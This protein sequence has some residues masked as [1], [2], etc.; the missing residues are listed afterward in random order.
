MTRD[1][2]MAWAEVA[3]I[4]RWAYALSSTA[5]SDIYVL[6]RS[7]G[8]WAVFYSERGNRNDERWYPAEAQALQDLKYR[9][10]RDGTARRRRP[11]VT[12]MG[13]PIDLDD[14]MVTVA[15]PWGD[16]KVPLD[17]W[18]RKGP[19]PRPFVTIVAARRRS[20]EAPVDLHEIAL[21]Y[22]N[23]FASRHLQRLGRLKAPWGRPPDEE[24]FD[25]EVVFQRH[26]AVGRVMM[27]PSHGEREL[28]TL[29]PPVEPSFD[30]AALVTDLETL[31]GLPVTVTPFPRG[32]GW[33]ELRYDS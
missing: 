30:A 20:D 28:F 13:K 10:E 15:H 21:E 6:E 9:L 19:G 22:R 25:T 33:R 27:E 26:G 4:D 14:S 17:E 24:D 12:H 1:E 16:I 11:D 7:A 18:I 2:F 8:G 32:D 5:V 31:L 29:D 3:G 23:T